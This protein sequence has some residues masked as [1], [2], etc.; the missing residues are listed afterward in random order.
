MARNML[1]AVMALVCV[2]LVAG[3]SKE[4]AEEKSEPMQQADA[5]NIVITVN[6]ESIT[7]EDV[8][9]EVSRLMQM[10]SR[11]LSP[12][13]LESTRR[14]MKKEASMNVVNRLILK[15]EVIKQKI[16][17]PDEAIEERF[18]MIKE[19]FGSEEVFKARI[20]RINMTEEDVRREVASGLAVEKL[21]EMQTAS[22]PTPGETELEAYYN[23]NIDRYTE[24]E[25]IR[26]SHILIK[27]NPADDD[28]V[29]AQKR[30]GTEEL[31]EKARGGANFAQLAVEHSEC[32]SKSRGGD[33]DFF[34]RGQMVKE[35]E[36]VAFAL[37]VGEISDV[38]ETQ[39]GYHI[40]K[41]TDRKEGRVIPFAEASER[42]KTEYGNEA[43]QQAI[44]DY[45]ERL[46]TTARITYV[47]STLID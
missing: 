12:Q 23:E 32:P 31:L 40:I 15:Q 34:A 4:K 37:D 36:A 5:E 41:A 20:A 18:A 44:N 38:V 1:V 47:D 13:D 46:K 7:D 19:D 26:A 17:I 2:M 24:P 28:Q 27:V 3:C 21:I 8:A 6:D 22:L 33:L 30:M 14:A 11:G 16:E 10:R 39:F 25:K 35:F 42:I 43:K 45:I 29:R 9:M